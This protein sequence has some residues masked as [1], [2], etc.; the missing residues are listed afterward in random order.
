MRECRYYS[1]CKVRS[2]DSATCFN[3][4][5]KYCGQWRKYKE[6]ERKIRARK[7]KKK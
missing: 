2:A 3:G 5:G 6:L 7:G 4:G 1:I